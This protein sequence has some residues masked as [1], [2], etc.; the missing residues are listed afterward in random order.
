VTRE[1]RDDPAQ[2]APF[3]ATLHPASDPLVGD[4]DEA[5]PPV[6]R[7]VVPPR[8]PHACREG[9]AAVCDPGAGGTVAPEMMK[10]YSH[11]RRQALNQAADALEPTWQ[12]PP[13]HLNPCACPPA[14]HSRRRGPDANGGRRELCHTVRHKTPVAAAAYSDLL[15]KVAPRVHLRSYGA[16]VDTLDSCRARRASRAGR[17][18]RSALGSR[19]RAT[20]GSGSSGWTRTSNPPVNSRM[21]CH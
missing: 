12:C 1:P 3:Q 2:R 13:H 18:L 5:P 15:G 14:G 9:T 20:R 17:S 11:I 19:D 10:T 16:T 6:S 21:L 8:T 4:V 7:S